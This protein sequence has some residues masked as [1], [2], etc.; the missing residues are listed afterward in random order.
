[1]NTRTSSFTTLL[2]P[3]RRRSINIAPK[4]CRVSMPSVNG[5]TIGSHSRPSARVLSV[6]RAGGLPLTF[7]KLLSARYTR[8][9]VFRAAPR[10]LQRLPFT[11]A[12][13][14]GKRK[15]G[16][17][18]DDTDDAGPPR[19]VAP[20]GASGSTRR[21]SGRKAAASSTNTDEYPVAP[22]WWSGGPAAPAGR[23]VNPKRVRALVGGVVAAGQPVLY[24]WVGCDTGGGGKGQEQKSASVRGG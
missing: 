23:L 19:A 18:T 4:Q 8:A 24:W 16:S 6:H 15:A 12:A 14:M 9:A 11:A 20:A 7:T 3:P 13:A 21:A 5:N 2:G 1:M 17:P 22:V 10:H